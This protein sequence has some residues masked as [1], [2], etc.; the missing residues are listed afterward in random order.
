MGK[1]PPRLEFDFEEQT[2]DRGVLH[3][4]GVGSLQS[5][6]KPA[7]EPL[8]QG[9]MHQDKYGLWLKCQPHMFDVR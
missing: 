3:G 7:W 9:N 2:A 4:G 1:S 6:W 8:I 5:T